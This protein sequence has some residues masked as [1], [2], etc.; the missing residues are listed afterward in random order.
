[1]LGGTWPWQQT[2]GAAQSCD[3]PKDATVRHR[4]GR[5]GVCVRV[6]RGVV[7]VTQAGDHMDYVLTAGE[8]LRLPPGGVVA[9]WALAPATI[10]VLDACGEAAPRVV[11]GAAAA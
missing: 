2:P 1:M 9:A 8:T 10:A 6:D 11:R 3:L 4:P 7:L 5:H